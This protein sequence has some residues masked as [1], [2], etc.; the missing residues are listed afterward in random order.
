MNN[1]K[2]HLHQH[3]S[4]TSNLLCSAHEQI[5]GKV[6]SELPKV[7]DDA[8][9][10][11]FR[12]NAQDFVSLIQEG[13]YID[14]LL[15]T[16]LDAE[17]IYAD[18][19]VR[20]HDERGKAQLAHFEYQREKNERMGERLL[21][22]NT[23]ASRLNTYLPVLSC[24]I[25]LKKEKDIPRPPFIKRSLNGAEIT[26]FNYVSIHLWELTVEEFLARARGKPSLLPLIPLAQGGDEPVAVDIMIEELMAANK[27][28]LLWIGY[29]LAA[30]VFEENDLPWLKRRFA[31]L[32]DF[33]WDSPVYQEIMSNV[34][35]EGRAEGIETGKMQ[36]LSQTRLEANQHFINLVTN[37]FPGLEALA[38]ECVDKLHD[39]NALMNLVFKIGA[40][41]T[42]QEAQKA[43]EM[44]LNS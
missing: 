22:Y 2:I 13:L 38:R 28:D 43:L 34:K 7:Y 11:L 44:C 27:P 16:E 14:E 15:P 8:L 3:K 20:C 36:A 17:H 1:P 40:A 24:V 10:K 29:S 26:R 5:F 42:R 37:N 31:M 35:E 6:T 9:K 25:Y 32:N 23:K 30:K 4:I 19:L 12:D 41:H 33:L 39:N 21:E 18:G